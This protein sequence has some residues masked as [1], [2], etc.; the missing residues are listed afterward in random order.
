MPM[1]SHEYSPLPTTNLSSLRPPD[2]AL[3][4]PYGMVWYGPQEEVVEE[5]D[6]KA[7]VGDGI[8]YL[9]ERVEKPSEKLSGIAR[10]GDGGG[11][12][13]Y[14]HTRRSRAERA[15]KQL[16]KIPGYSRSSGRLSAA[17]ARPV[18]LPALTRASPDRS[19]SSSGSGHWGEE[20]VELARR[21]DDG[22]PRVLEARQARSQARGASRNSWR[23]H[24]PNGPQRRGGAERRGA[25]REPSGRRSLP[26]PS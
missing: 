24:R 9:R 1:C 2:I 4:C 3:L 7:I 18:S 14:R 8:R 17:R 22:L 5:S 20:S 26:F 12:V 25:G 10:P 23:K 6:M 19:S 16:D 15:G 21:S 11:R 13:E